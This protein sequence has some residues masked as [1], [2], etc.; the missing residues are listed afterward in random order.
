MGVVNELTFV[1]LIL[2]LMFI[3]SIVVI[4]PFFIRYSQS[5]I[6]YRNRFNIKTDMYRKFWEHISFYDSIVLSIKLYL[7][8]ERNN[9]VDTT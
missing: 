9:S 1:V 4:I 3:L 8:Q 2:F 5:F 7:L 6:M